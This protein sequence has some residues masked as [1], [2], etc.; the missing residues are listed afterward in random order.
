MLHTWVVTVFLSARDRPRLDAE[1]QR[2]DNRLTDHRQRAWRA[3]RDGR[4]SSPG[5]VRLRVAV[6]LV[7]AITGAHLWAETYDR[8]FTPESI[9]ELQDDLVPRIVSTV[10]DQYGVLPRSMS[11][12]LR[13]KNEDQL[14]A[15][16]AVLRAFTYF[17]RITPEEHLAVRRILER[18]VENPAPPTP[19]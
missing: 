13:S 17:E 5:G 9:F 16:E 1:I 11:E 4:Q 2:P 18:A 7:D 14:T 6:Q 8:P 15:H 12:T 19:A 10:A 3:L